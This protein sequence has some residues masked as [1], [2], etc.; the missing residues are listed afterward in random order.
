M[1]FCVHLTHRG[2]LTS[3]Q[4]VQVLSTLCER[5]PP[6]GK[7]AIQ[8]KVLTV[9]QVAELLRAQDSP[10]PFGQLAVHVNAMT[11]EQRTG[12]VERQ[13]QLTPK[14]HDIVVELGFL[15]TEVV[16]QELSVF[17]KTL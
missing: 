13:F 3:T 9:A 10:M 6:L 8:E 5:T 12:L 4:C 16:A 17:L 1:R 11:E 15:S 7:L 14:A 2:L